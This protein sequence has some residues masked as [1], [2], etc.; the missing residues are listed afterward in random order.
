VTHPDGFSVDPGALDKITSDVGRALADMAEAAR[1]PDQPAAAFGHD[2]LATSAARFHDSWR[3]GVADLTRD[4]RS[5]HD[6]IGET[7][8]R[9]RRVDEDVAARFDAIGRDGDRRA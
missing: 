5:L 4:V 3:D 7:A 2:D 6:G 1:M 9:Y 8:A